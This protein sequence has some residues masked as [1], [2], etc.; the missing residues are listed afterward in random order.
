MW[1][2]SVGIAQLVPVV[3]PSVLSSSPI[4]S[5][6]AHILTPTDWA[7]I[8]ALGVPVC[9]LL[10]TAFRAFVKDRRRW[11]REG[12][13]LEWLEPLVWVNTRSGVYYT[14]GDRWYGKTRE[15]KMLARGVA[16]YRGYRAA[17]AIRTSGDDAL[18]SRVH[19]RLGTANK[20]QQRDVELARKVDRKTAGR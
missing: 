13:F 19:V 17:S 7:I 6:R 2:I 5:A 9:A 11:R 18:A 8:G 3:D 1:E 15:G 20:S 10:G 14:E 4:D 16:E 12:P